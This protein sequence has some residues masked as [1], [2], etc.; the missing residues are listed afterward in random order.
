MGHVFY[1]EAG[2][3]VARDRGIVRFTG[4]LDRA[5]LDGLRT[6]VEILDGDLG[7]GRPHPGA[8]SHWRWVK[9]NLRLSFGAPDPAGSDDGR[10]RL[11]AVRPFDTTVLTTGE[12][13]TPK[14]I[15]LK[16]LEEA[17]ELVEA[18]KAWL[19]HPDGRTRGAMLDETAD[20]LQ[21]IANLCAAFHIDE[22]ELSCAMAACEE[23]N[24]ERRR[25][26]K[27]GSHASER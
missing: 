22:R 27:E 19:K 26:G 9:G 13:E 5:E 17:A 3:R 14:R 15:P 21:T 11:P 4:R 18:A 12:Y 6:A 24:R 2:R 23:R 16:T 1:G 20:V 8:E 25:I 7:D 10:F